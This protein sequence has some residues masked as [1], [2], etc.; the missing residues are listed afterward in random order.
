MKEEDEEEEEDSMAALRQRCS[1]WH[2][3]H[4]RL[5]V[6]T[7]FVYTPEPATGVPKSI[8]SHEYRVPSSQKPCEKRS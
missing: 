3:H 5:H 6:G 8:S 1:R 4:D 7:T 2:R